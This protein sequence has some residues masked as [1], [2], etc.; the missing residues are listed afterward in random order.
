MSNKRPPF[1][2]FFFIQFC[3]L[4]KREK[5]PTP[6][7]GTKKYPHNNYKNPFLCNRTSASRKRKDQE[8][9]IKQKHPA[10]TCFL[11]TFILSSHK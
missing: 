2:T 4:N 9:L 8:H 10:V 6:R 1:A 7:K 11:C 3:F 5:R